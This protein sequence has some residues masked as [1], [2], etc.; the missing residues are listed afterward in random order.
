RTLEMLMLGMLQDDIYKLFDVLKSESLTPEDYYVVL[1]L[2][3]LYNDN[4]LS[5]ELILD[6]ASFVEK[7]KNIPSISV[8]AN[9][10]GYLTFDEISFLVLIRVS[11]KPINSIIQLMSNIDRK[12]LFDYFPMIY[13]IVL[14]R[15]IQSQDKNSNV[16]IQPIE[17]TDLIYKIAD[18]NSSSKV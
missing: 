18:L 2:L 7:L 9:L 11:P 13:G 16:F 17:L 4:L 8:D 3:S 12:Y 6:E 1:F 15:V 10:K 5:V 14:N